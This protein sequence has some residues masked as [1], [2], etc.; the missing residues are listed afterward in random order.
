M[1]LYIATGAVVLG[2]IG[3]LLEQVCPAG[4]ILYKVGVILASLGTDLASL[5]KVFGGGAS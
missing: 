5:K 2:S 1:V 4:S 3:G